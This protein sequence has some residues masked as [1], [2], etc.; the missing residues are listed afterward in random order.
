MSRLRMVAVAGVLAVQ[1]TGAMA[2]DMPGSYE[3]E[4]VKQWLP[5]LDLNTG[6]YLRGDVGYNWGRI[7]GAESTAPFPDPTG[8]TLG[9][10]VV[11]GFGAGIKTKWLRTDFTV[12]YSFPL[13]YTGTAVSPDD[14]TAKITAISV[15]FNAYLDLGTW[16]D[17]TP[18]IGAGAGAANLR[19]TD[20]ASTA[21]PPFTG[22][23]NHSQWNFAWAV[24]AGAGYAV[25]PNLII[26]VNYRYIDFGDATTASDASGS[27]T[28][29]D[30]AAHE[31]RVGLRWSFDDV[32][33]RS[34]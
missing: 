6:W 23:A 7:D 16:H 24:M 22:D 20:Y 2:A 13:D 1:V 34:W 33:G 3:P 15:L 21:T 32:K 18:Y 25:A 10:G 9:N 26:D 31:V 4:P 8:S 14:V 28:F 12:D 19:V 27:V 29:E 17:I 11:A 5:S 30:I